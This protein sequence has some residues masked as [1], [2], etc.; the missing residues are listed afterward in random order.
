LKKEYTQL[1]FVVGGA[2]SIDIFK[3]GDDKSQIVDRY[4]ND[5]IEHN[6]IIFVGDRIP[7]PGNDC[8]LATTLRQHPN[9]SAY[10]VETWEDTAK[11][12][13]TSPFV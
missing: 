12:L 3:I 10:E 1:D 2:V 8:S 4:F 5:A 11:L 9:G 7:F 6:N 13:K